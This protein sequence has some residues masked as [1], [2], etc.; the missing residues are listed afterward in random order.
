MTEGIAIVNGSVKNDGDRYTEYESSQNASAP[1]CSMSLPGQG[2]HSAAH[3]AEAGPKYI[4]V[5]PNSAESGP[6]LPKSAEI[7]PSLVDCGPTSAKI[8]RW[9][10][11]YRPKAGQI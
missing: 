11:R 5:E 7:D 2:S 3:F 8:M 10:P 9:L 4:Q 6:S 1:L